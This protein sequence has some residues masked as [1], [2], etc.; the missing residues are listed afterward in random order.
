MAS[1]PPS[2][3]PRVQSGVPR[4]AQGAQGCRA[5]GEPQGS[6]ACAVRQRRLQTAA[7]MQRHR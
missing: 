1:E 6:P 2:L 5:L 4:P 3:T 7:V